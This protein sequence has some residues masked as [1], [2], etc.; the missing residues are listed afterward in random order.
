MYSK[1]TRINRTHTDIKVVQMLR[2]HSIRIDFNHQIDFS[3]LC[4]TGVNLRHEHLVYW[5]VGLY[6]IT[7]CL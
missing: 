5:G 1:T 7:A 6:N 4:V 2:E 3:A